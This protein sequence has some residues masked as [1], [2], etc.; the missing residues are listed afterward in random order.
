[1]SRRL[2][3]LSS[4]AALA[5]GCAVALALAPRA[6]QP[7][8]AI[9]AEDCIPKPGDTMLGTALLHVPKRA[10]A[11]LPLVMAFHGAGGTGPGMADYSGLSGTAD[12]YG[13]AVLYPTAG[14]SR[15][16]WSLNAK[17]P[18]DDVG[19]IRALLPQ[20]ETAACAD[21]ARIYATGV[22]NG[23]GF[24]ARLGCELAGTIA[25]VAPVA[26][27]YR[28]LDDCPDGRR[29]SVL[30]IH[31]TSDHVVPY[32]GKPPDYKGAV[33]GFLA[34][35]VRRDGC[36]AKATHTRPEKGVLRFTHPNCDAGLAV[37]HLRLAGTDHGWPGAS[38][39]WPRHNPSQLEANEEVWRFFAKHQAVRSAS[40]GDS[41]A[42][43]SAG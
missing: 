32:N 17:M 11:P 19:R 28:A 9:A 14:S 41:R 27:G 22:S 25:A 26:G 33:S 29:T 12:H 4:L 43:R 5:V 13:F 42:A 15:H 23:G 2:R 31:G 38:P 10:T 16:F 7:A 3:L 24:S 30:E 18:P 1:M 20:A 35:W 21:P 37:E 34:G 36:D 6:G 39:P 40:V 8:R